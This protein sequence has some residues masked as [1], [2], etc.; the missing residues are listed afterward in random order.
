M[1]NSNKKGR[2]SVNAWPA[3]TCTQYQALA[4]QRRSRDPGR[5][6]RHTGHAAIRRE[7]NH[8]LLKVLG[9]PRAWAQKK[10][11]RPRVWFARFHFFGAPSIALHERDGNECHRASGNPGRGKR[12]G[13][14]RRMLCTILAGALQAQVHQSLAA[15]KYC[16]SLTRKFC[17]IPSLDQCSR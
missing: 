14:D 4:S 17:T 16:A 8:S 15:P 10:T 12:G 3:K 1:S 6:Q 2:A 11:S 7:S 13:L 5:L 9:G